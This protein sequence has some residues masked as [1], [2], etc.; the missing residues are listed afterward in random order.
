MRTFT[1]HI[2]AADHVFYE[3]ACESLILPTV[4]GQYG[5]LA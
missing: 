5:I 1:V 4:E 2:L 3:G